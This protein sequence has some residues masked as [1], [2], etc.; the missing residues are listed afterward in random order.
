M[1]KEKIDLEGL[2]AAVE[3]EM[4]EIEN[5]LD[6]RTGGIVTIVNS[7][8]RADTQE[9]DEIARDNLVLA[10][11]VKAESEAYV[12]VPSIAAEA[13]FNWMQEWASTV[14]DRTLRNKLQRILKTCDDSCFEAFREALLQAPEDER[15]RWFAF[16]EEKL[17]E[18]ITAWLEGRGPETMPGQSNRAS[19]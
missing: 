14:A 10:A 13:G 3:T 8:N 9:L 6:L 19:G 16:R 11:R 15:E 17:T 1:D 12:L 4:P 5:Y 7:P 2:I 18:F